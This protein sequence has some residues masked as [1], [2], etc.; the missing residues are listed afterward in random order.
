MCF[1]YSD[2]E[3]TLV[4]DATDEQL[5]GPVKLVVNESLPKLL[6]S[7]PSLDEFNRDYLTRHHDSILH[8]LT[9]QYVSP[10]LPLNGLIAIVI[11]GPFDCDIKGFVV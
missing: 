2:I 6:G 4:Q 8:L 1:E 5:T 3:I 7:K 10:N 9:G 11:V